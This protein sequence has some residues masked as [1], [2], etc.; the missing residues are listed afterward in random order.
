MSSVI[1]SI[2][3][4]FWSLHFFYHSRN[5]F[6]FNVWF[7]LIQQLIFPFLGYADQV[8]SNA[9][10]FPLNTVCNR[11][12]RFILGCPFTTHHC[13]VY[14]EL[15]VPFSKKTA[16]LLTIHV[17]M[18]HFNYP[19]YLKQF[20]VPF[21]SSCNLRHS[22]ELSHCKNQQPK[23]NIYVQSFLRLE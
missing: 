20:M 14:E 6:T 7:K 5:C 12:C 2:V 1:L 8:A 9:S 17:Q 23:I 22:R 15:N 21:S 10:P 4:K 19:S 18:I 16:A 13:F 11:L 3:R